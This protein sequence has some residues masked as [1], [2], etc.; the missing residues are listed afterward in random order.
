MSALTRYRSFLL[1]ITGIMLV[2]GILAVWTASSF[3]SMRFSPTGDSLF[4]LKG[5]LVRM[6]AGLAV[7]FVAWKMKP[8]AVQVI[9]VPAY[10][11]S[12]GLLSLTL[13][14]SGSSIAPV[15]NG[16]SRWL[17]LGP[18][19]L[20]PS[21][22]M[23]FA[24]V[25][26]ASFMVSRGKWDARKPADMAVM[27]ASALLPM[28]MMLLQPDFSGAAFMGAVL[29]VMLLLSGA[30]FR[31]M[32]LLGFAALLLATASVVT[33]PYRLSRITSGMN[34]SELSG[35]SYQPHQ[36]C[37]ALGSGGLLGRGLGRGRQQRGFLPE[38]FSDYILA[39]IGEEAGFVGTLLVL[40]GLMAICAAGWRIAAGAD[41]PFCSMTSGGFTS[42]VAM[43][44]L[45]HAGVVT[46]ILPPT[47]IPLPLMSWGGTSIVMTMAA[48]GFL[49]GTAGR[50]EA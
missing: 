4:F 47:G 26:L 28:I 2:L 32:A 30:R 48:L 5:H 20:L 42:I 16:S 49:A 31:H 34:D 50:A 3:A 12:L 19:R 1:W 7:G 17:F 21:E 35:G 23:R 9:A 40:T 22:L 33:S 6:F 24:F 10:L 25:L 38:A 13:I 8:A 43:G 46:K 41:T 18:V 39:V 36:A 44:I 29:M 15:I 11:V 37:I 27:I 14:M 45:I